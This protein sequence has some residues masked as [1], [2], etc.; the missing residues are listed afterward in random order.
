MILRADDD[1]IVEAYP[2]TTLLGSAPD[3]LKVLMAKGFIRQLNEDQVIVI[4]DWL[5][6]NVIRADR[7]VDSIYHH[8][9]VENAPEVPR[10]EAKPRSDVV[11]NS[12]RI[13]GGLSTDGVSQ[14]KLGKYN[15]DSFLQKESDIQAIPDSNADTDTVVDSNIDEDGNE[16]TVG[17][18]GRPL[19]T[20]P[21]VAK[22]GKNKVALRIQHKFIELCKKN[23]G[24][25]PVANVVGY[26]LAL[27]VL[28]TGG[29]T[30]EQVYDLF[31]EWFTLGFPDEQTI[32]IGRALSDNQVNAY[33][34]R[35]QV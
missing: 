4:T 13:S 24:T 27:R 30:E 6:H 19:K 10:L 25:S 16:V 2:L 15:D 8:L 35:N 22:E 33:K 20:G 1:G 28:N 18:W 9:L 14:V 26:K 3:N 23:V 12:R 5:E 34:V 21:K 31:D 11:D 29:L 32:S 7:K 17:K